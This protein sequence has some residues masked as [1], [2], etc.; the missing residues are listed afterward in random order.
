MGPETTWL[1]SKQDQIDMFYVQGD[2]GYVKQQREEIT[3][4]CEPTNSVILIIKLLKKNCLDILI[5]VLFVSVTFNMIE[6]F[7]T[8]IT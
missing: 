2:F 6:I 8:F 4:I 5:I 1:P 7:F 3:Y